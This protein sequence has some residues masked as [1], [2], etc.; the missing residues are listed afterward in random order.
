MKPMKPITGLT[1]D[2]RTEPREEYA[3][4]EKNTSSSLATELNKINVGQRSFYRN[5][6]IASQ[7]IGSRPRQLI[8]VTDLTEDLGHSAMI[9]SSNRKKFLSTDGTQTCSPK[10]TEETSEERKKRLLQQHVEY[11]RKVYENSMQI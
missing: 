4:G 9:K 5:A 10:R 11:Y 2:G 3:S 1:F 6:G 8:E 7:K